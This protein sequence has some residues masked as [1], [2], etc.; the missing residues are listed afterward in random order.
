[1]EKIRRNFPSPGKIRAKISNAWKISGFRFQ[2]LETAPGWGLFA[3]RR[4]FLRLQF[5]DTGE[6]VGNF[7]V[8]PRQE[9]APVNQL[10]A[11]GH[12]L[13][14]VIGQFGVFSQQLTL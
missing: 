5:G 10:A 13:G 12:H 7:G 2:S 11:V 1:L 3:A 4:R 9:I 6:E 14:K 8:R